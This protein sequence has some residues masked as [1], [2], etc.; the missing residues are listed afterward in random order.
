M[1]LGTKLSIAKVLTNKEGVKYKAA[2]AADFLRKPLLAS[3]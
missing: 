2:T 3:L 1:G